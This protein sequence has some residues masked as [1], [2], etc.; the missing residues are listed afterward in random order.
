MQTQ[1]YPAGI[2]V[3]FYKLWPVIAEMK[4]VAKKDTCR[5]KVPMRRAW[6]VGEHCVAI[7]GI[8]GYVF[9]S[10]DESLHLINV[11]L[12]QEDWRICK[13]MT[14]RAEQLFR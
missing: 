11:S 7:C 12:L 5:T 14:V 8:L 9:Y 4:I 1:E 6:R 2:G 3:Y 13:K 10:V